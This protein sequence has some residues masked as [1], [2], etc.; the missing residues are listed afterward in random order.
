MTL[1]ACLDMYIA[2][3]KTPIIII[4]IIIISWEIL[5]TR[6]ILQISLGIMF[7]HGFIN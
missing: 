1:G 4:I 2:A 5:F 7:H 3:V 6:I